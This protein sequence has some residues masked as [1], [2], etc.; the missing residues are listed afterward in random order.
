MNFK[1]KYR[2]FQELVRELIFIRNH[3]I[4]STNNNSSS[5]FIFFAEGALILLVLERFLRIIP[6]LMARDEESLT[7]LLNRAV[8]QNILT[9][10]TN[11]ENNEALIK[12]ISTF[13]N[14]LFHGLFE[15]SATRSGHLTK[16]EF[17][18]KVYL[19]EIHK[20]YDITNFLVGQI[21]PIT[22]ER[23]NPL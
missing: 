12:S 3:N 16:E 20:L 10:P 13:R 7:K 15:K 2:D 6:Q 11:P 23:K 4:S 19:L 21:N 5:S 14:N 18:K 22:G 8:T 17:F 1:E 9:L